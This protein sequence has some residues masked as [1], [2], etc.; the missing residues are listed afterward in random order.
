M[1]Y[2]GYSQFMC[3][4]GHY[5]KVDCNIENEIT[6]DSK[7]PICKEPAV[8]RNMVDVT[9]GSFD[10]ETGERVDNYIELK[11]KKKISGVCSA[12]GEE[13]ICEITCHKPKKQKEDEE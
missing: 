12:C 3:K 2:E 7:C 6:K 9:N 1:S 10:D 5:W 4:K 8:F 13:H 11:V